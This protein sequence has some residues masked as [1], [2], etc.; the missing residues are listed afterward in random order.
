MYTPA[1]FR[2]DDPGQ[3]REFV[4]AHPFGLLLTNGS[5]VPEVTHLPLLLRTDD[6]GNDRILGHLAKANPHA[7]ALIDGQAALV[8]FSGTHGYISPRWYVAEGN[9]PTWNYRSVHAT[10]TLRRIEGENE[11]MKLV[12]ALTAE[13]EAVAA[14]PWLADWSNP[15]IRGLLRAIVGFEL[16]VEQWEGKA[17]LGQNRSA[18]DQA[19]LR[20]NLVESGDSAHQ[21]LAELMSEFGLGNQAKT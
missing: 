6:S 11:L 4:Q 20:K 18:E 19:S 16:E 9:V 17:K 8:V 12:D 1:H 13:H 14:S 15:K 2:M 5:D 21:E 10:G 3:I 7:K